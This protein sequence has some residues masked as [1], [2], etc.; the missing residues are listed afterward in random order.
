MKNI[1]NSKQNRNVSS[2]SINDII[3]NKTVHKYINGSIVH[4]S[5]KHKGDNDSNRN[6]YAPKK[7][8]KNK[9]EKRVK[10]RTSFNSS[11]NSISDNRFTSKSNNKNGGK[12]KYCNKGRQANATKNNNM[13]LFCVIPILGIKFVLSRNRQK[14]GNG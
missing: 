1:K 10:E 9:K 14:G 12:I 7:F 3:A 8:S 13:T 2:P 11:N 6:I 4:T 5:T